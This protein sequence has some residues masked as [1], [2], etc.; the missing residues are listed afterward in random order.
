MDRTI[1]DNQIMQSVA[2][3]TDNRSNKSLQPT[4]TS[5]TFISNFDEFTGYDDANKF[6][7]QIKNQF[8]TP[9]DRYFYSDRDDFF[10]LSKSFRNNF[11]KPISDMIN[12]DNKN[13]DFYEYSFSS[14]TY[15]DGK[16]SVGKVSQYEKKNG[17]EKRDEKIL[18]RN[19]E[20]KMIY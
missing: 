5:S 15:S 20:K 8:V 11:F 16:K 7:H 3:T 18:C 1:N 13:S 19:G 2:N 12:N 10:G 14:E 6:F 9:F 17:I 4:Q